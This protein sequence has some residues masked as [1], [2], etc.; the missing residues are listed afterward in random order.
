MA[1]DTLRPMDP[2]RQSIPEAGAYRMGQI[3]LRDL[4]AAERILG[5]I[6]TSAPDTERALH[7][8]AIRSAI[9][10]LRTVVSPM[11]ASEG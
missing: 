3:V 11:P 9:L 1:R 6:E 2:Q 4:E 8:Q 10:D 5:R 7:L